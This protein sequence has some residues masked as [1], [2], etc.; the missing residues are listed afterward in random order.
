MD[1]FIPP[2][3][4]LL[5]ECECIPAP[6]GFE[7]ELGLGNEPGPLVPC[8]FALFPMVALVFRFIMELEPVFA[9]M[10]VLDMERFGRDEEG[11]P[12]DISPSSGSFPPPIPMPTPKPV[13]VLLLMLPF[14]TPELPM[15]LPFPPTLDALPFRELFNPP[16]LPVR[17][18]L[19][20]PTLG[21]KFNGPL[22][23]ECR[24]RECRAP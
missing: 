7:P 5:L 24:G 22:R 2:R 21:R 1:R 20:P 13:P 16:E 12:A 23:E 4:L 19:P 3:L 11:G 9:F 6:P 14:I 15:P 8:G 10:F 17:L 18:V